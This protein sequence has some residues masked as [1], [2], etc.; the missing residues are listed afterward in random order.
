[1]DKDDKMK[2]D[3]EEV[4]LL[5]MSRPEVI[6]VVREEAKKLRIDPNL[7]KKEEA[8]GTRT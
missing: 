1:W 4:K 7:R 5:A 8:Y 3:D 2:K 6:K